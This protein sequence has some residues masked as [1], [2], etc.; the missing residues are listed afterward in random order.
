MGNIYN[1]GIQLAYGE[2]PEV[3]VKAFLENFV[4]AEKKALSIDFFTQE[5]LIE[6]DE[7][8]AYIGGL[9]EYLSRA[10]DMSPPRWCHQPIYF[11]KFP[12]FWT[13]LP[14]DILVANT[15]SAFRRRLLFCGDG[16]SRIFNS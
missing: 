14:R 4:Q 7:I 16:V 13:E 6:D 2:D 10:T 8:R 9:A 11:L 5:P 1:L 3:V 12:V 15:P